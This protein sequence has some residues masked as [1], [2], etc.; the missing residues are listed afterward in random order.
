MHQRK[1]EGVDKEAL[2]LAEQ[3]GLSTH[4]R[5]AT[6]TSRWRQCTSNMKERNKEYMTNLFERL[7]GIP[8]HPWSS[9][10]QEEWDHQHQSSSR[11]WQLWLLLKEGTPIKRWSHGSDKDQPFGLL[12]SA[13]SAIRPSRFLPPPPPDPTMIPISTSGD[14]ADTNIKFKRQYNVCVWLVFDNLVALYFWHGFTTAY[15]LIVWLIVSGS[16]VC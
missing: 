1:A 3:K 8:S 16:K 6:G 12:R 2:S 14:L 15:L 4:L 13:I 5:R 11:N 7:S 9:L 10:L